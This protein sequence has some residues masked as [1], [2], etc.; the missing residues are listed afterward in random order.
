MDSRIKPFRKD[1]LVL[2]IE[3]W[4]LEINTKNILVMLQ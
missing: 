1:P 4:H 2:F 3:E